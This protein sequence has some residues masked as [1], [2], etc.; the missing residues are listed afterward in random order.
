MSPAPE[1]IVVT[2]SGPLREIPNPRYYFERCG[3]IHEKR[4]RP[5]IIASLPGYG[6]CRFCAQLLDACHEAAI[7]ADLTADFAAGLAGDPDQTLPVE[8]THPPPLDPDFCDGP[9]GFSIVEEP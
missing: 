7:D 6:G 2:L 5:H 4:K 8:F 3:A 9:V 1:L